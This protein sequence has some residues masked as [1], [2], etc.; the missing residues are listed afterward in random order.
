MTFSGNTLRRLRKAHGL[1]QHQLGEQVGVHHTHISKWEKGDFTP[2]GDNIK[3]LAKALGV[4]MSEFYEPATYLGNIP[5]E[6]TEQSSISYGE[7]LEHRLHYLSTVRNYLHSQLLLVNEEI[8]QLEN[9][10]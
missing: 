8:S 10:D 9:L 3:K 1:T 4:P 5:P 7:D 6:R 2:D